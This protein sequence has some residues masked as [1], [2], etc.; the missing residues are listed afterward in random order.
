MSSGLICNV[1]LYCAEQLQKQA[2]KLV[3]EQVVEHLLR[4]F[5]SHRHLVQLDSSAWMDSM[6]PHS[7]SG[8]GANID[9]VVTVWTEPTASPAIV[10]HLQQIPEEPAL[11]P[12]AHLQGWAGPALFPLSNPKGSKVDVFPLW[13]SGWRYT[14]SAS[15]SLCCTHCRSRAQAGRST[16]WTPTR[17]WLLSSIIASLLLRPNSTLYQETALTKCSKGSSQHLFQCS[18]CRRKVLTPNLC[19][20]YCVV[21]APTLLYD[22]ATRISTMN[23]SLSVVDGGVSSKHHVCLIQDWPAARSCSS[24][25]VSQR[26]VS[27]WTWH[28]VQ[29]FSF[30]SKWHL[31]MNCLVCVC[32]PAR[33]KMLC[34]EFGLQMILCIQI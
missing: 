22:V 29:T 8:L 11:E 2:R 12:V 25:S 19:K 17:L 10:L 4:P 31:I 1:C 6:F 23:H 7:F 24:L 27:G 20:I 18:I 9:L 5:C 32:A 33:L 3:V 28:P 21:W 16:W 26:F 13:A 30:I 15:T 34:F 14:S